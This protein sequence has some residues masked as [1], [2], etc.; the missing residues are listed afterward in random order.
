MRALKKG[1]TPSELCPTPKVI[2]AGLF[3]ALTAPEE[4]TNIK[5]ARPAMDLQQVSS[6]SAK[7]VPAW[8][9]SD[10]GETWPASTATPGTFVG[11][12]MAPQ[13]MEGTFYSAA[14]GDGF[15]AVTLTK[16]Y[17]RWGCW[18]QNNAGVATL[19]IAQCAIR[20]E[21]RSC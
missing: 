20:I 7:W 11:A 1:F 6:T 21:K 16:K 15:E 18:A 14:A 12:T 4:S 17:V 5:F 19:E 10:D 3:T 13:N 8:Q 9:Q 2:A